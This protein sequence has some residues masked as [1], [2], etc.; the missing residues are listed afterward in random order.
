MY[1]SIPGEVSVLDGRHP[2]G[3]YEDVGHGCK[4]NLSATF[5]CWRLPE[6]PRYSAFSLQETAD[7]AQYEEKGAHTDWNGRL[8]TH[9]LL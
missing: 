4:P 8:A 9:I 1:N 7:S 6:V 5:S 3:V 2:R